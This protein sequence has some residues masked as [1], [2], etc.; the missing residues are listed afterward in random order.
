MKYDPKD[1]EAMLAKHAIK[2]MSSMPIASQFHSVRYLHNNT[3]AGNFG[4]QFQQDIE[5]AGM[6]FIEDAIGSNPPPTGWSRGTK[7]FTNPM[8]IQWNTNASG[9]YDSNS[10]KAVLNKK[11][12]AKGAA[13]S[14]KLLQAG[15]DAIITVKPFQGKWI[16]EEMVDLTTIGTVSKPTIPG[17][18]FI[19]YHGTGQKFT[20]FAKKYTT[21]GI[22]W[23]TSEKADILSDVVGAQGHGFI[24]TAEV[25]IK[26]AAG[27]DEYEKS[28]D[29]RHD[30]FD[31]AILPHSKSNPTGPFDCFVFDAK[32]IKILSTEAR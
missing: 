10:W 31:G 28:M 12:N 26:N 25:T 16:T 8:V 32:Q 19:V 21:Q 3:A 27:W 2:G 23:F 14:K 13:L 17:A 6:Y 1:F 24:V 7:S 18:K 11:F 29:L 20:R 9:G 5:P 30:G 15:Y 4:A 22:F